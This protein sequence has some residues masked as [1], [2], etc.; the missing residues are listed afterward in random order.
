MRLK[1]PKTFSDGMK[2]AVLASHAS[3]SIRNV[4]RLAAGLAGGKYRV[5]RQN[6]SEFLK[7][8]R[9][10]DKDGR[11]VQSESKQCKCNADGC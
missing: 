9:V 4:V 1:V 10:F 2:I 5:V 7:F 6:M 11:G 8:G 3:E